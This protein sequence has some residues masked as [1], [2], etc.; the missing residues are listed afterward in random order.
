MWRM[1]AARRAR[2]MPP[3]RRKGRPDAS[4][5]A[6][7]QHSGGWVAVRGAGRLHPEVPLLAV[8]PSLGVMGSSA[9]KMQ[10]FL[11]MFK[12]ENQQVLAGSALICLAGTV[13]YG[14]FNA[15]G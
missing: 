13:F 8:S 6:L 14:I 10:G 12:T 9:P 1:M 15:S 7:S 3:E 11:K 2:T 5:L 4:P